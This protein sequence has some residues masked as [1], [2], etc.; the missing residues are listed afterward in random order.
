MIRAMLMV[1]VFILLPLGAAA[2]V[3]WSLRRRADVD[4]LAR[5]L[6]TLAALAGGMTLLPIVYFIAGGMH[7]DWNAA[8]LAP[9]VAMVRAEPAQ[10]LY[11]DPD[12]G[13]MTAWIY[14]PVPAL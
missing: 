8:K 9:I 13:V 2:W 12:T 3:Y 5:I 10:P 1:V 4:R 7:L 14:G 11:Q 6:I